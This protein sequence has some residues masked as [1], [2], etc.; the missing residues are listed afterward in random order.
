MDNPAVL[1]QPTVVDAA[2]RLAQRSGAKAL[3][4]RRLADELGVSPMAAYRHVPSKQ[5]L[6]ILVADSAMSRVAVPPPSAG[7]WDVRLELLERAAFREL[8]EVA[9]LWDLVPMDAYY[10]NRQR[11]VDAVVAMLLD[12]GFDAKTAAL[13]HEAFFGYVMGQLKMRGL[14][15]PETPRRGARSVPGV[16]MAELRLGRVVVDGH[17]EPIGVTEYFEFGLRMLLRGLSDEL[18]DAHRRAAVAEAAAARPVGA[19]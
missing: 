8:S 1:D 2:Y 16:A 3:T 9:D 12:A 15:V 7:P 10:P 13:A 18:R 19:P 17:E 5:K 4:M 14:L 11:L 6:F